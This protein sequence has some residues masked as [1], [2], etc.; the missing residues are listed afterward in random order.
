MNKEV[1][2][3]WLRTFGHRPLLWVSA[4][5][6]VIRMLL[7]RVVHTIVAAQAVTSLVAGDVAMAKRYVIIF[8]TL[9]VVGSIA[10]LVADL[11]GNAAENDAYDEISLKYYLKITGKD[12]SFYRSHQTGYLTTLFRQHCDGLIQFNRYLRSEIISVTISLVA[13]IVVLIATDWRVGLASLGVVLIQV[14]YVVRISKHVNK[15]RARSHEVY[16][17]LS[18][19]INDEITNIVA[20]KSSGMEE[21]AHS[22][23][24][25]LRREE[26]D[27]FW[28][29]FKNTT[30]LDFPRGVITGISLGAVFFVVISSGSGAAAAGL[31]VLAFMYMFQILRNVNELPRLIIQHDDFITRIHPSLAYLSDEDEDIKNPLSPVALTIPKGEVHFNKIRFDYVLPDSKKRIPVFKDFD[32]HIKGGE[33]IGIVGLSGA[34]KSTLASLLLRFDEVTGG[35]ITIDG[36]DIRDVRQ[37]DLRCA[38]GYVPQEPL[39]FHCSVRRNI[40][41]FMDEMSDEDV[42]KAAKVA[43]AHEFISKL[44]HGYDTIVGERGMKLSGGQKQRIAIARAI[45]KNSPILL[46]DEATSALDSESEQIIQK[47]MPKIIGKHTA[48]VIAHRL[49]TIAGLDRIVVLHDGHVIEQGS[50]EQLLSKKGR[51]Y[52]LWQKQVHESEGVGLV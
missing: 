14:V 18:G 12:M 48:I 1:Y 5:F 47:A 45:M 9:M 3:Y 39:L 23:V 19:E 25:A 15:L 16:R 40:A 34:G 50:H 4:F 44:P 2:L 7:F 10:G 20:F 33:Q 21:K 26:S 30:L 37:N 24:T 42:V 6:E 36:T 32:L 13:P 28:L 27:I 35:S 52:S 46:F 11:V 8:L 29:R 22:K 38:I 43:H 51:Y 49:S 31:T 17:Q 41:Y